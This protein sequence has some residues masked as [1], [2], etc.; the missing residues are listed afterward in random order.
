M[1]KEYIVFAGV[2]GAGKSTLYHY[3]KDVP[4]K[5]IN[6]DE[7]LKANGGDWRNNTDQAKAMK[8][9]VKRISDYLKQGISFNQETTLAGYSI[10]NNIKKAKEQ[11][12][13]VK[14]FY[15]GLALILNIR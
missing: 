4:G 6:S 7:I 5:R 8:E 2:N 1:D 3:I 10:I 12:Y 9:A 14:V 13:T 11:G 15:V